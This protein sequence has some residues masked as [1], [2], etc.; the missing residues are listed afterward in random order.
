MAKA[1]AATALLNKQLDGLTSESLL[2]K[3]ALR[4]AAKESDEFVKQTRKGSPD[5]DRF[6]GRLTLMAKAASVLGPALV[7]LSAAA[8]GGVAALAT[9]FGVVAAAGGVM[10]TA[11]VG[12]GD[13]LEALNKAQ[14]E[15][16]AENLEALEVAMGN[17]GPA[18]ASFVTFLD[19]LGPSLKQLQFTAREGLLPGLEDGI[20]SVMTLA[21]QVQ[22]IIADLST[23]LG[24]L[25]RD[26]GAGLAGD[27]FARF[28]DYL[29]TEAAPILRMFGESVGNVAEGF[30]NLIVGFAPVTDD[31]SR[32]LLGM[33][34]R[35]AEWSR[36]LES[37]QGFQDFVAYVRESGP[38]VLD[39]LGSLTSMLVSFASAVAP[40]GSAVLPILTGVADAFAAIASN[41]VG[42]TLITAAAGFAALNTAVGGLGV[43]A[44]KLGAS[45]AAVA[46]FTKTFAKGG[47]QVVAM[48]AG[49]GA[50]DAGIAK[51]ADNSLDDDVRGSLIRLGDGE[52]TGGLNNLGQWLSDTA[53]N[54]VGFRNDAEELFTFGIADTELDKATEEIG[55]LDAA[56]A[57]MVRDGNADQA[58]RAYAEIEQAALAA[59]LSAAEAGERFPEFSEAIGG[60][61]PAAAAAAQASADL[62]AEQAEV[63]AAAQAEAAAIR[64]AIAAMR[65]KRAATLAAFDAETAY[66]QALKAALDPQKRNEA[67]IRGTSDAAVENRGRISALASAWNN[68]SEAVK[69]NANRYK[70]AREDF[71][72]AADAMGIGEKQANRLADRLLEIPEKR[73]TKIQQEG[74]DRALEGLGAL[75]SAILQI[76]PTATTTHTF[77]RRV[78]G[79]GMGPV[80]SARGNLFYSVNARGDIANR[81]QP[82]IARGGVTRIWA[83]PETGGEA[84]IPLRNDSR[85]PRA[86]AILK[87][88]ASELGM[89]AYDRGGLASAYRQSSASQAAPAFRGSVNVAAPNMNGV[90]IEGR[91]EDR[92]DGTYLVGVMRQVAQE[93]L[94][95]RENFDYMTGQG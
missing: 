92:R 48:L 51:L 24:D 14:L 16:T 19:S 64:D 56:L 84:Y 44:A 23:T 58:A 79:T 4:D 32:G 49:I 81:H 62:A 75:R 88:T 39:L 60:M 76:P 1:A 30:A 18:G 50:I 27:G 71:L 33:T 12:V 63:A 31:F 59:G 3:Q 40:I 38:Q 85:R 36:G 13:G 37:N 46:G 7:P 52:V 22:S 70:S 45:Q 68:Q 17:L 87:A 41:P 93:V 42:S 89:T 83:E 9:Q 43:G 80:E 73:V 67:G 57:Q 26:A 53:D 91:I 55:K 65:E 28:F 20:E 54:M 95:D 35:F 21:P 74:L 69:N 72:K 94:T 11:L 10:V 61:S 25:F 15:P 77:V 2:V 66:R 86:K 5:I 29:D 34:Q 82:Q 8:V 6:S 47:P 78:V 90:R